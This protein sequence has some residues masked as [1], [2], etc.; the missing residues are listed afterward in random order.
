MRKEA[1]CVDTAIRSGALR[2][3]K[4]L[5]MACQRQQQAEA[6]VGA[7]SQAPRTEGEGRVTWGKR[8]GGGPH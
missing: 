2:V 5:N 3:R 8:A 1:M 6:K 7:V 4:A